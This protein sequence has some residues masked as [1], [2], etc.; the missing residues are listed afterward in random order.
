MMINQFRDVYRH[1]EWADSMIWKEVLDSEVLRS[2]DY[3][4]KSLFH[5]HEV[6]QAFL[7]SWTG[8][9]MQRYAQDSFEDAGAICDW[10]QAFY[11]DL[12]GFLDGASEGDLP[13][14]HNLPWAKYFGRR[15]GV[16]AADTTL[17]ETMHQLSSHSMHHR[18]Q[19]M[20]RFREL[21]LTPPGLDYIV[22]AWMGRPNPVWNA[23]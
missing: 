19:V 5:L 4:L 23:A 16:E 12:S 18:G 11:G 6:Q 9:L 3:V 7:N 17:M 8:K 20:R 1:M 21:D 14:H 10:G 2:D 13:E 15:L 22:W